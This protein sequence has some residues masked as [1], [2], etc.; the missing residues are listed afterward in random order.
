MLLNA[1][2]ILILQSV[3][4]F[5]GT[6]PS[7]I[8]YILVGLNVYCSPPLWASALIFLLLN[9]SGQSL[10]CTFLAFSKNLQWS[11]LI[12]SC[13]YLMNYWPLH[14]YVP[15]LHTMLW[16]SIMPVVVS[17]QCSYITTILNWTELNWTELNWADLAE[18]PSYMHFNPKLN[19][20]EVNKTALNWTELCW[21]ELKNDESVMSE[22]CV[23]GW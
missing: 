5:L 4:F 11:C 18:F 20:A 15:G 8:K 14:S 12:C 6:E 22:W 19:W 21:A 13:I 16:I 10:I 3:N 2:H 7:R 23:I 17:I 9:V 1:N